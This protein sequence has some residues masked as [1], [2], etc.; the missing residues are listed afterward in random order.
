MQEDQLDRA[1][2]EKLFQIQ[3]RS[4]LLMIHAVGPLLSGCSFKVDRQDLIKWVEQVDAVEGLEVRRRQW[5]TRQ[6]D[7]E[8]SEF[9]AA[10]KAL[11]NAGKQPI[12]FALTREILEA[13]IST[14]PSEVKIA[15]G[16]ITVDFNPDDPIHACRLLYALGLA[17]ASDFESFE[18][19]MKKGYDAR[20]PTH[21]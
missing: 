2:I 8:T 18:R 17:L 19:I 21:A 20:S 11:R 10:Q 13:T 6:I 15:P 14:L 16:R 9:R 4:A 3:R 7:E 12:E 1:S 5:R